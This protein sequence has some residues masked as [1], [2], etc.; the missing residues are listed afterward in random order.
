MTTSKEP[1]DLDGAMSLLR[2]CVG[3][4]AG[5]RILIVSEGEENTFYDEKAPKLVAKAGR[6]LGMLIYE[7]QSNATVNT[8]DDK[9][10]LVNSLTGFDHV[11][12]FSR[13]GDQIRFA[14]NP[15]MP[16][17]TMCY[18][19]NGESLNSKFGT[20]CHHGMSEIKTAIDSA[21]EKAE[22]IRVTCPRGTDYEGTQLD[23]GEEKIEVGLKRFPL[24]VP[25]PISAS[26]FNG[27]VVLSRFLVGTGSRH[28]EPYS[29]A[30]PHDVVAIVEGHK[31]AR[32]EGAEED[33][34]RVEDHYRKV[35]A[36]FSI[37]PWY[38]DSWHAG[39]HPGCRFES[40]AE[41]DLLRWSGSAFGNPRLLH[42]HTCGEYAPG[43]ITWN[44]VDPTVYLD[45]VAV[46]EDGQLYPDRIGECA[47]ILEHHPMLAELFANPVRQIGLSA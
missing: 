22:H 47:S 4:M 21:F 39:I 35:S 14:S 38:V 41:S 10:A 13:V 27:R 44:I 6:A 28:Y 5:E 3:A 40:C 29:L 25:R 15:N 42:F 31:I 30:M 9:N 46:W 45:G 8:D 7:T 33:V 18:T 43:E 32:F 2:N 20:A 1:T 17:S 19:L 16:S 37:E 23:N 11:I 34:K 36:Q 12:F 26:G 24:L